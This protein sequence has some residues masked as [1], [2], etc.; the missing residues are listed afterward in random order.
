[1]DLSADKGVGE[2]ELLHSPHFARQAMNKG[3]ELKLRKELEAAGEAT[4]RAEFY[5]GGGLATGGEDRRR[6]IREWLREKEQ[7]REQRDRKS[8]CFVQATFWVAAAT[9]IATVISICLGWI[10][11]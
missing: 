9:L 4:V 2:K 5:N 3:D 6:L 10:H 11:K 7:A 8:I 1:M